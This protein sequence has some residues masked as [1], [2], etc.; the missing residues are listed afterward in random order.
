[1]G[2][3]K[4]GTYEILASLVSEVKENPLF[5]SAI[6]IRGKNIIEDLKLDS[7]DVIKLILLIEERF[8]IKLPDDIDS[9]GLM[10]ADNMV[11]YLCE[12]A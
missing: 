9:L 11:N 5:I 8:S 6:E 1:M 7:L 12:R 3:A 4:D 2:Q 10:N